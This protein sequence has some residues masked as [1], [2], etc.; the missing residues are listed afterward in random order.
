MKT[1]HAHLDY[2]TAVHFNRDA[3]LIVSCALDGLMYVL[4][5]GIFYPFNVFQLFFLHSRIWN[6][7]D[8]QCL[9]TLAEGHN[10]IWYV[11]TISIYHFSNYFDSMGSKKK[12]KVNMFNFRQTRN[13]FSQPHTIVLSVFGIIKLLGV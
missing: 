2:V 13:I 3:T 8:G 5:N 9:K 7:S 6:T 12:K 4:F 1:L 11:F 10:A